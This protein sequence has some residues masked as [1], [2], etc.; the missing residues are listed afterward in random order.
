M[1]SAKPLDRLLD[2][3]KTACAAEGLSI[4]S[5]SSQRA[6]PAGTLPAGARGSFVIELNDPLPEVKGDDELRTLSTYK[7]AGYEVREGGTRLSTMRP[8][9]LVELLGHPEYAPAALALER[10]LEA[11]LAAAAG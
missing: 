10:R 3:L 2:D 5:V 9:Q 11:A 4:A 7:V 8:S 1:V 6:G